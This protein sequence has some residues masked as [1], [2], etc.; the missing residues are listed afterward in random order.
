MDNGLLTDKQWAYRKNHS[1]QL[2]LVHLTECWRQ[3][4]DRNLVVA[5]AFVDFRKAFDCVSHKILLS[6]LKHRFGIEGNLLSWLTDYLNQRSQITVVNSTQSKKL[7]VSCGIPQGS[8]LGPCLFSLYTN[9]MPD[10]VSSGTLYLYADDTTVYCI[11]STVDEACSLLNKA[12]NELNESC[13]TNSLTPHSTKCEAMLLHRGSFIGPHPLITIGSTTISWVHHTRLLGVIIDHKLTWSKHLSDLKRNFSK[14]LNLLKKCSFLK[15]RALLDLYFKVILP[16]VTYGII[17]WGVCNNSDHIQALE[18]LHRRAARIIFN[19]SWDTPSDMVMEITKWDS[20]LDLYKLSLIKLFYNIVIEKIPKTI[21]DLVTWRHG[22]YNLRGHKKAVVPLFSTSFLKNSIQHR[23][24]FTMEYS[25]EQL[26]YFRICYIAFNLVPEGLRKIFKQEWD[27]RYKATLGEWKD[28]TKNGLDFYNNEF[29]KSSSKNARYLAT[30]QNG[31]TAEWDCSCL[32]FAILF[33]DSIGTTVSAAI[34]KEVDDLRQVRNDIAHISEA[35][36]TDAEFKNYVGRVL[37]AFNA[38]SLPVNDIETVKNHTSF[39]TAEVNNLKLHAANLLVELT[40]TKSDLQ[41]AQNTIQSKEEEVECLTREVNSKV[42]SFCNLTFKPSHEIIRRS[43]DVKRIMSKLHELHDES[44]GAVSTIYLSGNP[45]CGKTQIAREIGQELFTTRLGITEYTLTNLTTS[46]VN[47]PKEIVQHLRC[48]TL[49]KTTQ[50]SEWLIIADNVVDLSLVRSYL[51]QTASEEWGHGQVLITTQD[52]S[53]IP[54]N[55]P[56]TYR[57][58]LSAGMQP[59]DAVE[60]LKQVAQ[61][62]NDDQVQTVAE[63]L[64]YQPLAL[65]AAAFY[66]K[67][68]VRKGSPN[69]SWT[70][71]MEAFGRGDHKATQKPLAEGNPAYSKTMT[72][73]ITMAINS[74][75]ESNQVLRQVLLFLSL[76][77]SESLP[78]EAAVNFVKNRTSG[79]T[80][81]LIRAKIL[82]SSLITCL[83]SKDG[84]PGYIRVHNVIHKA[85]KKML[86]LDVDFTEKH[87]IV[88][89]LCSTASVCC[90]ISNPSVANLFSTSACDFVQYI[91]STREGD[92]LKAKIFEKHGNALSLACQ[93]E[94]SK[95]YHEKALVI[96]KK[97]Y[98]E[99]HADVAASYN[100]L[101]LVH[102]KLGQYNEAKEYNEK[103]LVIKKKIFDEEHADVAT[104]YNN[105][106][107]V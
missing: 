93:Y 65:A 26:N 89:W 21:S 61:M 43:N 6:K 100:K 67:T 2:L 32:F 45:G 27:F 22:P 56:H 83:Y 29:R 20:I 10:A 16:S 38:L 37:P 12:L 75:L 42:E 4:L 25:S 8:V 40:N 19:L 94:L 53:V 82:Q 14:K 68:V 44:N 17:V 91:S 28:T 51:P 87:N 3:A 34:K 95:S 48:L 62:S 70:N 73:A 33:S 107:I 106:G 98:G 41:V 24:L 92:L 86:T 57:E 52:S 30:I 55:A 77:D 85:L 64:D 7:N 23:G 18:T 102:R 5:T 59:E 104:S 11:G 76:C 71:Y 96:R 84:R 31:N 15:R 69:Y 63:V 36:L 90:D 103:A 74:A 80:E 99:E 49:P 79:E 72:T 101:G 88:L 66:V 47:S 97:N 50:F 58:S 9:D 60:L 39:P 46:K 105:L 1:T 13:V 54:T 81:E 78:V 35:D